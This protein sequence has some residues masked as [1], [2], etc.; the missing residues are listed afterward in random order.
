MVY[1]F[2][3]NE[4]LWQQ[5]A[6]I[7]AESLRQEKGLTEATEFYEQ[8]RELM[9]DASIVAWPQ[10]YNQDEASAIQHAMNLWLQNEAA[11]FAEYQN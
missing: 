9:D 8:N 11:F 1:A 2:P 3:T 5:Y 4:K 10:R 6:Q 7:R